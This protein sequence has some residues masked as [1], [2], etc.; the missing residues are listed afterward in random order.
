MS[1]PNDPGFQSVSE[2]S[3]AA[4]EGLNADH[5]REIVR[6]RLQELGRTGSTADEMATHMT[7]VYGRPIANTTAGARLTEMKAKGEAVKTQMRRPTRYGRMAEVIV[8]RG[9][10]CHEFSDTGVSRR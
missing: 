2:C 8:L 3:R 9:F 10:A 5:Y 4:A 7:Q 1:Y 6:A